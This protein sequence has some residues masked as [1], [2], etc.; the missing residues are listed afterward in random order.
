MQTTIF[1]QR[2]PG[3]FALQEFSK[4]TSAHFAVVIV[5]RLI[6]PHTLH[7]AAGGLGAQNIA[8]EMM[9]RFYP[10][11]RPVTHLRGDLFSTIFA[12]AEMQLIV[13]L[14]YQA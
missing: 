8:A 3:H 12:E 7:A 1:L 4:N 14:L 11:G 9:Q 2:Q 6:D 10:L 13:A 5:V